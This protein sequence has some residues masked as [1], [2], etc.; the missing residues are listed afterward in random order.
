MANPEND[1]LYRQKLVRDK[2]FEIGIDLAT[3]RMFDFIELV[4]ND[5]EIMGKNVYGKKR[6]QKIHEAMAAKQDYYA[7]AWGFTEE[8][9]AKQEE[10][11][12]E[13]KAIFGDDLVPFRERYPYCKEWDY[14]KPHKEKQPKSP[15]NG[16]KLG[17]KKRK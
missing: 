4:L 10:L 6:L 15:K 13:L 12:G 9:D 8:S 7:A 14:N 5:K 3:Q 17:R 1:Y 11:D 2:C 16:R